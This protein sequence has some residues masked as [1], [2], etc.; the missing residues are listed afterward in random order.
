MLSRRTQW[1]Q[2]RSHHIPTVSWGTGATQTILGHP[3]TQAHTEP[4][5]NKTWHPATHPKSLPEQGHLGGHPCGLTLLIPAQ[6][7]ALAPSNLTQFGG[8]QAVTSRTREL[9]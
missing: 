7:P 9:Q 1:L 3:Q 8:D 4:W 2:Q 6:E 5:M